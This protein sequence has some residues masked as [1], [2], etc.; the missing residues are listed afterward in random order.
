MPSINFNNAKKVFYQ[1]KEIKKI[2]A[3]NQLVWEADSGPIAMGYGYVTDYFMTTPSV[4]INNRSTFLIDGEKIA[5]YG[6]S[7]KNIYSIEVNYYSFPVVTFQF[8]TPYSLL[9]IQNN[10]GRLFTITKDDPMTL[11]YD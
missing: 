5:R 1:G 3:L 6:L 11:Y 9:Q 10:T 8:R 7:D 4:T 2:Y